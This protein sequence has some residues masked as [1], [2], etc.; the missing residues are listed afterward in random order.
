MH[1]GAQA[2]EGTKHKNIFEYIL[3][4]FQAMTIFRMTIDIRAIITYSNNV[5][6]IQRQCKQ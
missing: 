5:N 6:F 4:S 2:D 1:V 3:L